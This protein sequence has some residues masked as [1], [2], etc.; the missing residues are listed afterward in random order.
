MLWRTHDTYQKLSSKILSKKTKK[1]KR[2]KRKRTAVRCA[3]M[4]T[5]TVCL[6][7][8]L[9]EQRHWSKLWHQARV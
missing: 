1:M 7:E 2:R 6:T 3:T 9:T 8:Y 4:K 5:F